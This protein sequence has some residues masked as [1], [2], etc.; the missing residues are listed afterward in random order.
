MSFDANVI[1]LSKLISLAIFVPVYIGAI[2]Y[3][4]WKP[5]QASFDRMASLPLLEDEGN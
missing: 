4:F 3:A 5:N 2:I 1:V